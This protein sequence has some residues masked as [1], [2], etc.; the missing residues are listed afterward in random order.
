[1]T[2]KYIYLDTERKTKQHKSIIKKQ[3]TINDNRNIN[4]SKHDTKL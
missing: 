2:M 3:N 4:I 1:M